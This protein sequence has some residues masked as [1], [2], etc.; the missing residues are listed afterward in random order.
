[1][2]KTGYPLIGG[3]RK[4][5]GMG[6]GARRGRQKRQ[7]ELS[8]GRSEFEAEAEAMETLTKALLVTVAAWA[9]LVKRLRPIRVMS[10]CPGASPAALLFR[11]GIATRIS[12]LILL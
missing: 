3:K 8:G 12:A 7:R 4:A 2:T 9:C 11:W 1:M 6:N 5:G 10:L